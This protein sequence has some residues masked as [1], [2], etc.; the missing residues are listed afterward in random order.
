MNNTQL[1]ESTSQQLVNS[2]KTTDSG[3]GSLTSTNKLTSIQAH[4]NKTLQ[5]VPTETPIKFTEFEVKGELGQGGCGVIDL[6]TW[7]GKIM[8]ESI[9]ETMS[10][11]L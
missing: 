3:K 10:I 2:N 7:N 6:C 5:N 4:W 9:L 1:P 8:L 11:H